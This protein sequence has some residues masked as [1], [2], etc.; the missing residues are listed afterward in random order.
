MEGE[1]TDKGE[2]TVNRCVQQANN[3]EN[4]RLN[5]HLCDFLFGV[6]EVEIHSAMRRE[7]DSIPG[8]RPG[9]PSAVEQLA[10]TLKLLSLWPLESMCCNERSCAATKARHSQIN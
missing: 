2:T 7:R 8:W 9:I 1:T 6:Q 4:M 5:K 10:C 3:L